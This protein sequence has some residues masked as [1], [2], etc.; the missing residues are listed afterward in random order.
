MHMIE[1]FFHVYFIS[2][3]LIVFVRKFSNVCALRETSKILRNAIPPP[4]SSCWV[5]SAALCHSL[6]RSPSLYSTPQ[7]QNNTWKKCFQLVTRWLWGDED[8]RG[9]V[10][11]P[12]GT[13]KRF[14]S[15][16]RL[17]AAAHTNFEAIVSVIWKLKHIF[18]LDKREQ[19]RMLSEKRFAI[20]IW[21]I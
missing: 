13:F 4:L 7:P 16:C 21:K 14:K 18:H 9:A 3:N 11:A 19:R 10:G 12:G 20:F 1:L 8:Q 2:I 17:F 5:E 15:D 6:T